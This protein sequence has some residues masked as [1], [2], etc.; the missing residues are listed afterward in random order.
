MVAHRHNVVGSEAEEAL[1]ERAECPAA[2][3]GRQVRPLPLFVGLSEVELLVE[4]LEDALDLGLADV[5]VLVQ[6]V[7]CSRLSG[8]TGRRT[9]S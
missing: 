5:A 8:C 4:E 6:P 9:C 1:G 2:L 3:V 7:G